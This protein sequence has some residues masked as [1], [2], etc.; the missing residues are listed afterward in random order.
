MQTPE[1]LRAAIRYLQQTTSDE[2]KSHF[3]L[4]EQ[5]CF[6]SDTLMFQAQNI[7]AG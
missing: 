3:A 7:N 4:D 6:T 1:V 2:V 5:G